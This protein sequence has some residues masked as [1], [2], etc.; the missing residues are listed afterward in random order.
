MKPLYGAP[1]KA[2]CL[3]IGGKPG[4]SLLVH[5]SVHEQRRSPR[6][7]LTAAVFACVMISAPWL[8]EHQAWGQSGPQAVAL[9]TT[10][11]EKLAMI[12]NTKDPD[13]IKRRELQQV[14]DATVDVQDIAQFCLGRFWKAA[15]PDERQQ[16]L[17]RFH[18]LLVTE[19]AGH[20]GDY[21]GVN[22][23]VGPVE[24]SSGIQIVTTTV[25]RPNTPPT[26]ME[27]VVSETTGGPKIIDLQASG[28]SMRL[29][30]SADFMAYLAHH[31]Y[32]V[33]ELIEALNHRVAP[34]E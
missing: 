8:P 29:T 34:G 17:A 1:L 2:F 33:H 32:D 9:V 20:L 14:I 23:Q 22:V 3:R 11:S 16:Y 26:Q 6:R 12:V 15:T 28:T 24:P 25:R 18:E 27:W 31:H 5:L 19:I 13:G 7:L 10:A 21:Q 30:H 4:A